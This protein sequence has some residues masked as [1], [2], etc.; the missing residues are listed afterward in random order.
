MYIHSKYYI[1]FM[2]I[3]IKYNNNFMKEVNV[4]NLYIKKHIKF[5]YKFDIK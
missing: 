5:K 4:S 3:L 1:I 2:I